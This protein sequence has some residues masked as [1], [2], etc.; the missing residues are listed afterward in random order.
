MKYEINPPQKEFTA[1]QSIIWT[2]FETM[3]VACIAEDPRK[4]R[5]RPAEDSCG[6]GSYEHSGFLF[7]LVHLMKS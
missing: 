1:K 6:R 5:G 4:T 7:I 3:H 2:A